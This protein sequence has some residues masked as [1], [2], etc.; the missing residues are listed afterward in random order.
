MKGFGRIFLM[1]AFAVLL[2]CCA[3][4]QVDS[5]TLRLKSLGIDS[6][7]IEHSFHT[8]DGIHYFKMTINAV[9]PLANNFTTIEYDP[10]RDESD[11]WRMITFNNDTVT[12]DWAHDYAKEVNKKRDATVGINSTKIIA[13]DKETIIVSFRC[14]RDNLPDRYKD[15]SRC[16]G[17]AYINKKTKQIDR[18]EFTDSSLF[19]L[20]NM[21]VATYTMGRNF[22]F[23]EEEKFNQL[24]SD[25]VFM[26]IYLKDKKGKVTVTYIYSDYKKVN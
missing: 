19:R 7:I 6:N 14:T 3:F 18:E 4:A 23:N 16:A 15:L 21:D 10:Q 5:V 24:I 17:L 11:R 1:T 20:E 9:S 8:D 12:E 13:E 26:N 25:D 22:S 2:T